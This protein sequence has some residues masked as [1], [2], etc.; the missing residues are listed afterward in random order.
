V[1]S[2]IKKE[3]L[4]GWTFRDGA[5]GPWAIATSIGKRNPVREN[6]RIPEV[7]DRKIA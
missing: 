1:K 6:K 4:I 7:N 3:G 5:F 2:A